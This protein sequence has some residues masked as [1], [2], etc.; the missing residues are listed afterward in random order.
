MTNEELKKKIV[1]VLNTLQ[2]YGYKSYMVNNLM[3]GEIKMDSHQVVNNRIADALIAA[4]L[5]FKVNSDVAKDIPKGYCCDNCKYLETH[6]FHLIDRDGKVLK[7]DY[8]AQTICTLYNHYVTSIGVYES[9][10]V[11]YTFKKCEM[12]L[13]KQAEQELAEEKK[14]E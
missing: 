7:E 2:D 12:C 10:N 8:I 9:N 4:G 5:T 14:D 11:L 6:T 13:K 1:D 3:T